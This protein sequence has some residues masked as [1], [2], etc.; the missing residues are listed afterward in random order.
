MILWI[1]Y[2]V[3]HLQVLPRGYRLE[4]LHRSPA[5][6]KT[7]RKRNLVSGGV[8]EI[9]CHWSHK[10]RDLVLRT[11]CWTQGWR[12]CTE[13]KNIFAKSKD[14]KSGSRTSSQEWIKLTESSKERYGSKRYFLPMMMMMMMKAWNII[15]WFRT[16]YSDTL[17]LIRWLNFGFHTKAKDLWST[18]FSWLYPEM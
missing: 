16:W 4:Y 9:P 17:M 11:G 12:P 13:K 7:R 5:S 6:R 8:T 2:S 18:T 3:R 10:Y 14:V 15:D 1:G